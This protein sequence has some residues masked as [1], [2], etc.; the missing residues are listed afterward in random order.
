MIHEAGIIHADMKLAN[1]LCERPTEE[2]AAEG[3]LTSLKIC[4]FGIALKMTP[5][6]YGGEK[7][8]LM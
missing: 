5:E 1:I 2:E 4:D 8:A 7:K 3:A 6:L